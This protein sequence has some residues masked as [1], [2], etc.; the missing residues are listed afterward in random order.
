MYA[1]ACI[2][3]CSPNARVHDALYVV[4]GNEGGVN[5]VPTDE[6]N[7]VTVGY[8]ERGGAA[9]L[10]VRGQRRGVLFTGLGLKATHTIA[11]G[12]G[13]AQLKG[14]IGWRH[15]SG[16]V[17]GWS[18]QHFH[19]AGAGQTF[20]SE[21]HSVVRQAWMLRLSERRMR[22]KIGASLAFSAS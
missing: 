16:D 13:T 22:S 12:K 6:F 3:A 10:Q 19:D 4:A 18:R 9:A 1:A 14:D 11:T 20:M 2:A 8:T 17:R 21:G 5:P 15:A 7:G